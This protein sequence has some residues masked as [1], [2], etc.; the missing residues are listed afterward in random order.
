MIDLNDPEAV[1]AQY[2][3]YRGHRGAYTGAGM[4]NLARRD[5]HYLVDTDGVPH[6]DAHSQILCSILGG[7]NTTAEVSTLTD[8][9]GLN[10]VG[11]DFT[12]SYID[13]LRGRLQRHLAAELGGDYEVEFASSGTA[14]NTAALRVSQAALEGKMHV[15]GLDEGYHGNGATLFLLRHPAWQQPHGSDLPSR[16][17]V[18]F[19][20][21]EETSVGRNFFE[22]YVAKT[23]EDLARG[24]SPHLIAEGGVQG[25]AGFRNIDL[26]SL[27]DMARDAHRRDGHVHFDGVQTQPWRTGT[28]RFFPAGLV[29]SSDPLTIPDFVTSAKGSGDGEPLAWAA[30][31]K[32]VMEAARANGLGKGYDTYGQTIRGA[33]AGILVDEAVSDPAFQGNVRARGEQIEAGFA[34]LMARF[35]G[36]VT[37]QNGMGLMRALDL[38]TPENVAAFRRIG[39]SGPARLRM[40]VGAGGL[41]GNILRFGPRLDITEEVAANLL[42]R[43]GGILEQMERA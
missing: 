37:G 6:L 7:R 35:P 34:E 12:H 23:E 26:A 32:E 16:L 3:R 15:M 28:G 22:D 1:D 41:R 18:S 25:V 27:Q 2:E 8:H 21:F 5:G 36:I 11:A 30:F 33:V 4:G 38:R 20:G 13:E 19:A 42:S 43:T 14:A 29:D 17:P 40:V 9:T 31:R 39:V 10:A 24:F